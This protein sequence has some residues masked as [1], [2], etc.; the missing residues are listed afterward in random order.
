MYTKA[1]QQM[2]ECRHQYMEQYLKEFYAEWEG[3]K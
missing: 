3:E 1:A 2:A